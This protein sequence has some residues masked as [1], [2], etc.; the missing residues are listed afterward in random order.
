MVKA[1]ARVLLMVA[2]LAAVLV[3]GCSKPTEPGVVPPQ[4]EQGRYVISM[5]S[6]LTFEP[7]VAEVPVGAT[8][9]W[10]N[11]SNGTVHDVAGYEGD[12]IK[13]DREE[14]SS[15]RS[16]PDGLGRPIA[17]GEEFTHTFDEAGSWTLW[18]HTHHE[19]GMKGVLRVG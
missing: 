5:T 14:F 17:P 18:C 15:F 4:D 7:K 11:D 12:P 9:V 1:Y 13:E 19:Q 10:R 3:A 8:V 6:D 16:P 2:S